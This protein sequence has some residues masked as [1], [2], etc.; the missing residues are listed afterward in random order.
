[1]QTRN[2][3]TFEARKPS[4]ESYA[5]T[6]VLVDFPCIDLVIYKGLPSGVSADQGEDS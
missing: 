6:E 4:R 1:M 5:L 3:H 2:Q